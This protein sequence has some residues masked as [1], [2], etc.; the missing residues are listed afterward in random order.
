LLV[1]PG[2]Y[3][4]VQNRLKTVALDAPLFARLTADR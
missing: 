2:S 4:V 1:K 3:Y